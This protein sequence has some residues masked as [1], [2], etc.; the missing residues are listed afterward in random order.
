MA[1]STIKIRA[2]AA[3]DGATV[4]ALV[5]H[6]ME[7]GTRKEKGELVPAHHITELRAEV[8]GKHVLTANWGPAISENPYLSFK[9]K[10]AKKGDVVK[11]T[12]VDNKGGSDSLEETVG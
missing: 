1:E 4:K 3:G 10:G 8:N 6:P 9:V 2:K 11:L 12:W 5:R 7:T